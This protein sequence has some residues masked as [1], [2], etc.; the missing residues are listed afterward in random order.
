MTETGV[1][2]HRA[3]IARLAEQDIPRLAVIRLGGT[4]IAFAL[5]LQL[6]GRAYG[7]TMAYDPAYARYG[8]GFEAKL[9]SLQASAG[10]GGTRVKLRGADAPHKRRLT[11]RREPVYQAIGLAQTRLGRTGVAALLGGIRVRRALKRSRTARRVYARLPP[12]TA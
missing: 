6:P 8:V 11:D 4:P 12:R 1:E 2:F 10:E 5:S 7:V 9:I 3:A